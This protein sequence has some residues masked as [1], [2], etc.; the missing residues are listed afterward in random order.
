MTPLRDLSLRILIT[1]YW[2]TGLCNFYASRPKKDKDDE[3]V[4]KT[5]HHSY[6]FRITTSLIF[7]YYWISQ[8]TNATY[9]HLTFIEMAVVIIIYMHLIIQERKRSKRYQT[10]FPNKRQQNQKENEKIM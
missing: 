1:C 7:F 8:F 4:F 9:V 10:K 3:E 2:I 6:S 5:G